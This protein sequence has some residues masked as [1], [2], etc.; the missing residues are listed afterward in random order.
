ML[1]D[2]KNITLRPLHLSDSPSIA[3]HANNP[4]VSANLRDVFQCPYTESD[5][6]QFIKM[7]ST[8]FPITEFAID[9]NGKT[10]GIAGIILKE[11]VYRGNGEIGYW[12][13]QGLWG[14]GIG[15]WVVKELVRIAFEEL[16]LY[17]VYAEVF[18]KNIVSAHILEKNGLMK[19]AILKNAI[20][21]NGVRQSLNI[22]SIINPKS[23]L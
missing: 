21:K 23:T 22:Y 10:I 9:I 15:T 5:A 14:K 20:T 3:F 19:E 18:E 1:F 13:G 8:K 7:V 16:K 12:I 4:Q 2:S 6:I 17:R 11:D